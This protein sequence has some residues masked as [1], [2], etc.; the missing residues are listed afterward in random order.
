MTDPHI[1]YFGSSTAL[2]G[3]SELCLLRMVRHFSHRFRTTLFLP[4]EGPLFQEAKA[5][6]IEAVNLDFPRLRRRRGL[7]WW[8]WWRR[9]REVA[10]HLQNELRNRGVDLIHFND[11]IDLPYY[12]AG[13][14]AGIPS[15]AHLRLIL[16][17]PAGKWIY[18]N[19]VR[20]A[21]TFILPVSQAV[22]KKMLETPTQI[23]HRVL[24][25][26]SPDPNLFFPVD[27]K[28]LEERNATRA[29]WGWSQE[30]FV[31]VMVSKL[32]PNKGHLGF[33]RVAGELER[34][35]PKRHRF[36][37]VAGPT[38]GRESYERQV[39]V[40]FERLPASQREWVPGVRNPDL[41]RLLRAGDLL[42]HLP[43]TED[44][45]PG[46]VLE[47]MAC[48]VPIVAY[49]VGGVPEQLDGGGCGLL[50]SRG[51]VP[52]VVKAVE[53]LRETPEKRRELAEKALARVRG[54]FSADRHFADLENLY[55]VLLSSSLSSRT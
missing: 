48:G 55:A 4:D 44:S 45:F 32:L 2:D 19:W 47:A 8:R 25:D 10:R 46:V 51:D 33:C 17:S 50:V 36:L 15:V 30:D 16:Q 13:K 3:G 52:R 26:P 1:A 9:S 18:R 11:I 31:V 20:R 54:V 7:G 21:G 24:Y 29:E 5:S 41:P 39:R 22:A 49:G 23:P 27:E 34:K 53:E 40:A 35:D 37:M 42:L 38:S 43:D 14:K 12:A 28:T 6:G